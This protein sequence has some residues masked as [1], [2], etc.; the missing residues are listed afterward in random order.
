MAAYSLK[1]GQMPKVTVLMSVYN[2][3]RYLRQSVESILGQTFTDFEFVIINDGSTDNSRDILLSY[4]DPRMIV[5]DNDK[6]V[7]LTRSLNRGLSLARGEYVARQD[8]DDIS[9]P[10][11]LEKQ[12]KYLDTHLPVAVLGTQ[13]RNINAQGRIFTSF[14]WERSLNEIG[15]RWLCMFESPF[16]H[17][18]VMMRRNIIRDEY[19]GYDPDYV[20]SQDYELWTRVVYKYACSNLGEHLIYF[21]VH[22]ESLSANYSAECV[23][24]VSVALR[25]AAYA[26][27]GQEPPNGWIDQWV[28]MNNPAL[29]RTKPDIKKIVEMIDGMHERFVTVYGAAKENKEIRH[30]KDRMLARI[31]YSALDFDKIASL[32]LFW[33]VCR[34]DAK[35]AI[36]ILPKY[37]FILIFGKHAAVFYNRVVSIFE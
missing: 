16:I 33:R 18:S 34:D 10:T 2:G 32:A 21:R 15:I 26:G 27:L 28:R 20:S 8:A 11:R 24:A 9:L 25:Q 13:A 14:G 22:P 7:G 36:R 37:I 4:R 31:A 3:Q 12:A 5:I 23:A 6:N 29:Y 35:I 19:K 30:Q 1:K 17:S